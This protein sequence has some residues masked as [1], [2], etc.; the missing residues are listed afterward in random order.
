MESGL[1]RGAWEQ[2]KICAPLL[3]DPWALERVENT[4][5]FSLG[6]A[7]PS[8]SQLDRMHRVLSCCLCSWNI[9]FS[10][11]EAS[12]CFA[13]TFC[14]L[15]LDLSPRG[16][17]TLGSFTLRYD[18][19]GGGG[20]EAFNCYVTKASRS[21]LDWTSSFTQSKSPLVFII[22]TTS[23]SMSLPHLR[24]RTLHSLRNL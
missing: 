10:F 1:L 13:Y 11:L 22:V 21:S 14:C 17:R 5:R 16:G 7:T 8:L 19:E 20:A 18:M 2:C 23:D 24:P 6:W 12:D 4:L 3:F 15:P 9:E